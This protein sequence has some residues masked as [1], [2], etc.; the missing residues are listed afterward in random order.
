M[1]LYKKYIVYLQSEVNKYLD[2]TNNKCE[3]YIGK[4]IDKK[5]K[6]KFKTMEGFFDYILHRIDGWIEDHQPTK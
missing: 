4:I 2:K 5:H 6:S 3:N 1:T